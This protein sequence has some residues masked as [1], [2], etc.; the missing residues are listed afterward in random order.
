MPTLGERL[1]T[2]TRAL[3][4]VSESPRTDAEYLLAHALGIARSKL[5]ARLSETT[6]PAGFDALLKRRLAHE[7]VAYILGEWE[8][9]SL[10]LEVGA[11]IL[12]PRPE[13]EHLVEVVLE[14]VGD[15]AIRILEIGTGTGC[16]AIAIAKH[17][18]GTLVV[19]TDINPAALQLAQRNAERHDLTKRIEW[20][21][22]SLYGALCD[23]DAPFDVICSNP[24][25]V[26]EVDYPNLSPTIRLHED[27]RALVAGPDGLD[28]VRELIAHAGKHLVPGGLL[29]LEIGLGQYARVREL[30]TDAGLELPGVRRDLAGIERIGYARRPGL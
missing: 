19:A 20:R 16:V 5:L 2:V 28:I 21:E 29:A 24:P 30:M 14:F 15:R 4:E 9:Y 8:F 3:S 7:P 17:A 11:P 22:G 1:E 25:Y 6:E 18:P 27:R 12:V 10:D 26:E 23:D 13:T